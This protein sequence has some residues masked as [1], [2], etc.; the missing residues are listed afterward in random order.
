MGMVDPETGVYSSVSYGLDTSAANRDQSSIFDSI[1]NIVTKGLPLTG[2]SIVNSFANTG[3]ELGNWLTDGNAEKLTI[4]NEVGDG[5]FLGQNAQDVKDYY[6]HHEQGIEFA[7]LAVGSLIPGTIAIKALKLAQAGE[8]GLTLARATGIFSGPKQALIDSALSDIGN[9]ASLFNSLNADKYKVIAL[10]VGDQALQ[11]L[12]F[13]VATAAT[14]KASPILDDQGLGDLLTNTFYGTVVGAGIGGLVE[15]IGIR[16]IFNKALLNADT[17]SKAQEMITYLGKGGYSSGDRVAEILASL[18]KIPTP[19]N[20]LEVAKLSGSTDR[21]VLESKSIL[22]NIIGDDEAPEVANKFFDTLMNMRSQGGLDKE[23][24]YQYLARL[25]KITRVTGDDTGVPDGNSFYINRIAKG[26]TYGTDDLITASPRYNFSADTTAPADNAAVKAAG[27]SLK[28]Q[29]V[30]GATTFKIARSSDIVDWNGTPIP[31]HNNATDAFEAGHDLFINKNNQVSVNPSAVNIQ[32]VAREGENRILSIAEEKL[33]RKTGQLPEGKT[34]TGAPTILDTLT[35]AVSSTTTPVVGDFGR[36]VSTDKG[37]TYGENFSVQSIDKPITPETAPIDANARYVWALNRGIQDG[38]TIAPNDLPFLEKMYADASKSGDF[39][40]YAKSLASRK[41]S[42]SDNSSFPMSSNEWISRIQGEKN[43]LIHDTILANGGHELSSAEIAQITGT[44]EDYLANF[45]SPTS[46]SSDFILD[47]ALESAQLRNIKL[48]Y[49]I[50]N[51][52]INDGMIA[53]GALDVQYRVQTI[54]AATTSATARY[55]GSDFQ[56]FI[57][58][59]PASNANILGT[60]AKFLSSS[61][62]AYNSFGQQ[63]E[64]IGRNLTNWYKSKID[65]VAGTLAPGA[66]ALRADPQLAAEVGMFRA[67]RQ[68]TGERFTFLP[69]SLAVKSGLAEA[70][71]TSRIAVLADS[72]VRDKNGNILDWDKEYLPE[73]FHN[74]DDFSYHDSIGDAQRG[75][76]SYY[77]LSKGAADWENSNLALNNSRIIDRNNFNTAAGLAKSYPLDTLYTPPINTSNYRYFALAKL[78]P[79]TGMGE[80]DVA[81]ITG[82][83]AAELQEKIAALRSQGLSVYTKE[84]L[85]DF[86]TVQGDYEYSRNFAQSQVNSV[87]KSK[88][89]LNDILPETRAEGLI[90]DYVDWHSRQEMLLS[91]DYVEL[92]NSQLFAELKAMGSRFEDSETSRVGFVASDLGKSAD[93]PYQSYINTALAI[94]SKSTYRLWSASQEVLESTFDTAFNTAK[95]A[96]FAANKGIIGH[97]EASA[98]AQ[99]MG[100]GN[101]YGNG[102]EVLKNYYDIANKLP[103]AR[104]LSN[105]VNTANSILGATVIKLDAFQQMIHILSTPILTL[106]E[107]NSAKQ[108]LTTELPD[109]TGRAIPA[110]SKIFF[111]ALGDYFDK[112]TYDRWMPEYIKAGFIRDPDVFVQQHQLMD[113]LTLPYGKFSES[114]VSQKLSTATKLAEKLVG[115]RFSEAYTSWMAAR[116]GHLIFEAAGYQGQDLLDNVG[117]FVNRAKANTTASQRPVAFQGPL[118]Q[119][120]GLFQSYYFNLMQQAFRYV[121]NGEGKTLAILGGIQTSLFG[122]SSL[123]GFQAINNHIIGNA[124]GNPSHKDLYSSINNLVDPK[125]GDYLLYGVTSNWLNAGLFSRG[126]TNPRQIT[127]LPVNPLNFP[128]IAGGIRFVGNLLDTE[129]KIQQ[130]GNIPASLLLGLEHN[131]LSRPLMGFAQLAQGYSTTASG[132]LIAKTAP[133]ATGDNS[134]GLSDIYDAGTFSRLLGARPLDEA[135]HLDALYR[136]DLYKTK[137]N[138]RMESLGEAAKTTLYGNNASSAA[139]MSNFASEYSAAGGNINKFGQKVIEWSQQANASIANKLFRSLGTPRNVQSMMTMGGN[140]LPDFR[141]TG[142][143]QQGSTNTNNSQ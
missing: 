78:A 50:G 9:P 26:E 46:K 82:A 136:T 7:G 47:H 119:A 31:I 109:G 38:D 103:P 83:N 52:T 5:D 30:D 113:S 72:L 95:R 118:G 27:T 84:D 123:P 37:L 77:R 105:F 79:G 85:K 106:A 74:G 68:R 125:L 66:N 53:R 131:G 100:L 35:G 19:T 44:K 96:L 71:G 102:V 76:Y 22:Q 12:V 114:E 121:G 133:V 134:L 13:Q 116:T 126:D 75:N 63:M 65:I 24:I 6:S 16:G 73:N 45:M 132:N 80:D 140:P 10:G 14:M 67:V 54:K 41:V 33:Y 61:N 86:H 139:E 32:R 81:A 124:S 110:T 117:T 4:A 130:G 127:L 51:T 87:L 94:S 111:K 49:D 11:A 55:F 69:D 88:G 15:G 91:R 97:D 90:K 135:I 60:G 3:I 42:F 89:I 120:V 99:R 28:Y 70:D 64:R 137:D 36:L 142:G 23:A 128:A 2:L 98:M 48:W 39:V 129:Q 1:S 101:V 104:I 21:A 29:L 92:G 43:N 20:P 141:N 138:D 8:A 115:T 58:S 56:S 18:D 34:L 122:L 59:Q 40:A 25:G 112:T 17:S 143:T 62:S 107:A 57:S 93:N 108:F